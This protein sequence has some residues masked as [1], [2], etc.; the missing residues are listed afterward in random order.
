M[1][2]TYGDEG[3]SKK[4]KVC[5]EMIIDRT[6]RR[7]GERGNIFGKGYWETFGCRKWGVLFN[8]ILE[9]RVPN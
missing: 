9:I 2:T 1:V 8:M 6:G 5:L 4:G 3:V 7:L